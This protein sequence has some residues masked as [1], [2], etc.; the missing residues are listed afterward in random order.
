MILKSITQ[1]AYVK[2]T[3]AEETLMAMSSDLKQ[4]KV[5][6][7]VDE[8][9]GDAHLRLSKI[10]VKNSSS[11][12]RSIN[13]SQDSQ[14]SSEISQESKTLVINNDVSVTYYRMQKFM[15]TFKDYFT[16]FQMLH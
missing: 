6:L 3:N 8:E 15:D 11:W 9:T 2:A 16:S 4:K 13:N 1:F 7:K 5:D 10:K 14:R 12:Q